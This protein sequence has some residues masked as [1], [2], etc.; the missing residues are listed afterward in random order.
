[1]SPIGLAWQWA[2]YVQV[3]LGTEGH[4]FELLDYMDWWCR[5]Q[6]EGSK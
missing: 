5:Q 3:Y 1:M 2:Y 6:S 4:E